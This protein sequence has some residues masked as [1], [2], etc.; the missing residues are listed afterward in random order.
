MRGTKSICIKIVYARLHTYQ[1]AYTFQLVGTPR[2]LIRHC[3]RVGRKRGKRKSTATMAIGEGLGEDL[4]RE[5]L[6]KMPLRVAK[7][8]EQGLAA[9]F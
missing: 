4:N 1:L 7:G 8:K 6:K 5:G 9:T 3:R 2:C